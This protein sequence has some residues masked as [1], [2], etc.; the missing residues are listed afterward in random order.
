LSEQAFWVI[1]YRA[2]MMVAQAIKKYKLGECYAEI[3]QEGKANDR[4]DRQAEASQGR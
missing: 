4:H 2:V 3:E 1:I